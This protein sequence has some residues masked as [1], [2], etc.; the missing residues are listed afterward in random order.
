M[1]IR[2]PQH[3]IWFVD[4]GNYS[5][6]TGAVPTLIEKEPSKKPVLYQ[7]DGK[8]LTNPPKRAGF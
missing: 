8:P 4:E 2:T 1:F 3:G 6:A 7:A 5:T